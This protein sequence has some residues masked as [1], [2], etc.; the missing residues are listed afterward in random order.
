MSFRIPPTPSPK[1]Q[2]S[3]ARPTRLG[4]CIMFGMIAAGSQGGTAAM[5]PPQ[6]KKTENISHLKAFAE[7][8]GPL[9]PLPIPK[10]VLP[11]GPA[12]TRDGEHI[13]WYIIQQ[14]SRRRK[15]GHRGAD[16]KWYGEDGELLPDPLDDFGRL[17]H[18][19]AHGGDERRFQVLRDLSVD[20]EDYI[21]NALETC[22]TARRLAAE[23]AR[24]YKMKQ[25][26]AGE[27]RAAAEQLYARALSRY[28][29]DEAAMRRAER[30]FDVAVP[31]AEGVANSPTGEA[32]ASTAAVA[33]AEGESSTVL[34]SASQMSPT[35]ATSATSP[36]SQFHAT[37]TPADA[38]G[39]PVAALS[40]VSQ[41]PSSA[42]GLDSASRSLSMSSL[43]SARARGQL[44]ILSP[45]GS[46][47]LSITPRCSGRS[48]PRI[49]DDGCIIFPAPQFQTSSPTGYVTHTPRTP[50]RTG[51]PRAVD[52]TRTPRRPLTARV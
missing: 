21:E 4:S 31:L 48:T 34:E 25:R 51:T 8:M 44:V 17:T 12:R 1:K 16:G 46:R 13:P 11:T 38:A 20:E 10:P 26:A 6:I 29:Q 40:L 45:R 22:H 28:V 2:L 50:R 3:V 9:P 23:R 24:I 7:K 36:K 42:R 47:K 49:D 14:H 37:G 19:L 33:A 35:S 5:R 18:P 32:A 43:G 27:G 15:R 30:N 52:G 41:Q 39:P